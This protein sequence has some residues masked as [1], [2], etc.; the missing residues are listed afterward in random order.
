MML[1][2][3]WVLKGGGEAA[4]IYYLLGRVRVKEI[5]QSLVDDIWVCYW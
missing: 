3:I 4:K 2:K 5:K 1:V